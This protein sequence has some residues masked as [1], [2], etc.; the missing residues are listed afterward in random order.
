MHEK[1]NLGLRSAILLLVVAL[2]GC[3]GE[4]EGSPSSLLL[5]PSPTRSIMALLRATPSPTDI[6]KTPSTTI[7]GAPSPS[8]KPVEEAAREALV[9]WL[10]VSSEE[11][12]VVEVEEV[13]WPDT[14]LGCPQPGMVYAQVITPGWRV[15]LRVNDEA[16]EYHSGAG[17]EVLCDQ[18]GHLMS[19]LPSP[20][21]TPPA[22]PS[23]PSPTGEDGWDICPM[24][25]VH[26][27][28]RSC[29]TPW[30]PHD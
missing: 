6:T 22:V 12:E 5:T 11:V 10:E 3:G 7:P 26:P 2:V 17:H 19:A 25:L 15:V 29:P 14:S 27:H 1:N 24:M 4:P 23:V 30:T 20:T 18:Q 8:G 16:Y 28:G 9:H 13:E 21:V